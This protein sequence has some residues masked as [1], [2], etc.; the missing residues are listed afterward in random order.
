MLQK[1]NKFWGLGAREIVAMEYSEIA[2]VVMEKAAPMTMEEVAV[3]IIRRRD[4]AESDAERLACNRILSA[5]IGGPD[6]LDF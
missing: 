1:T 3:E 4:A 5:L 6:V 2:D